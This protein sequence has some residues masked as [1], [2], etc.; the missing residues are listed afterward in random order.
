LSLRRKEANE[1]LSRRSSRRLE[2]TYVTG[3]F[4]TENS[5]MVCLPQTVT[6]LGNKP[7]PA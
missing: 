6:H 5:E 1:Q 3:W 7:D 2:S 4:C